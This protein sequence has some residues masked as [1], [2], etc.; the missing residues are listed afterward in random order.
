MCHLSQH[1]E[2]NDCG[3][4]RKREHAPALTIRDGRL[5]RKP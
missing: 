1:E 2:F 4:I 5:D 3:K